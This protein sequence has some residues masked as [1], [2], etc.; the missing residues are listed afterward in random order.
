MAE[1]GSSQTVNENPTHLPDAS[2]IGL[3]I[4][5]FR[6][7][8]PLWMVYDATLAGQKVLAWRF[9]PAHVRASQDGSKLWP[10]LPDWAVTG[11]LSADQT[12]I[13]PRMAAY[14]HASN[15]GWL[16]YPATPLAVDKPINDRKKLA[17]L[18]NHLLTALDRL[19]SRETLHLD[20]H[21]NNVR[22]NKGQFRLVGLGADV[23][24][25]AG[26]T[27]ASNEG[28][29]RRG[30]SA[31]EMWD[32][33]G[34][35]KL[36][37]WTDIFAA[38]AT[39]YYAIC[40]K[41]PADFR[42]RID[43]PRWREAVAYDLNRELAKSGS[44]WPK[45]VEFII[46][47]LAPK[48]EDRPKTVSEWSRIWKEPVQNSSASLPIADTSKVLQSTVIAKS[49]MLYNV[50]I[51]TLGVIG[52]GILFFF[53]LGSTVP[54]LLELVGME[55][56]QVK[57]GYGPSQTFLLFQLLAVL[58]VDAVLPRLGTFGRRGFLLPAIL[59]QLLMTSND[60]REGSDWADWF[61]IAAILAM[62]LSLGENKSEAKGYFLK[63]APVLLLVG[64][65][66]SYW[67]IRTLMDLGL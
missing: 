22:D 1:R 3:D 37:P 47:G 20:V 13:V 63:Y 2:D 64:A 21:P 8:S 18:S 40:G 16:V 39:M 44:A 26:A 24:K 50:G 33:S 29:A 9:L 38:A 23:R 53:W 12:G 57:S 14:S 65:A 36:G 31:P 54:V 15:S 45:M 17:D 7:A 43:K 48:I 46:A 34:R 55:S 60:W 11:D 66:L 51:G 35:S 49:S 41:A 42:E 32:A 28:L 19:H 4:L 62:W 58:A 10:L 27:T 61:N 5:I 59:A 56:Y 25:Q 67:D 6:R 30:Y 52:G